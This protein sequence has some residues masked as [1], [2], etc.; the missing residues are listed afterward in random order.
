MGPV[1]V[2]VS[3]SASIFKQPSLV[4]AENDTTVYMAALAQL[5]GANLVI[6]YTKIYTGKMFWPFY[7]QRLELEGTA[8]KME[9]GQQIIK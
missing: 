1:K 6:D 9:G 7:W 2:K 4:T 5:P 3:G 8:C